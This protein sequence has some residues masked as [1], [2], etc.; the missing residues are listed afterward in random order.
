[1]C[2]YVAPWM[3]NVDGPGSYNAMCRNGANSNAYNTPSHADSY[4]MCTPS[5]ETL[6]EV[7]AL[8][9]GASTEDVT[10]VDSSIGSEEVAAAIAASNHASDEYETASTDVDQAQSSSDGSEEANAVAQDELTERQ[11]EAK[12]AT[13][14]EAAAKANCKAAQEAE[15]EAKA[16]VTASNQTATD[17]SAAAAHAKT[18]LLA[19]KKRMEAKKQATQEAKVAQMEAIAA[20]AANKAKEFVTKEIEKAEKKA[21]EEEKAEKAEAAAKEAVQKAE[22]EKHEKKAEKAEKEAA[23]KEAKEKAAEKAAKAEEEKAEKEEVEKQAK[24][25]KIEKEEKAQKKAEEEAKEKE[26]KEQQKQEQEKAAAEATAQEQPA[27]EAGAGDSTIPKSDTTFTDADGGEHP[28]FRVQISGKMNH[29]NIKAACSAKGL[30]P[31]C[32]GNMKDNGCRYLTGGTLSSPG[33][34]IKAGLSLDALDRACFYTKF[35]AAGYE[36]LCFEKSSNAHHWSPPWSKDGVTICTTPPPPPAPVFYKDRDLVPAF[37]EGAINHA[38]LKAACSSMGMKPV[39]DASHMTHSACWSTGVQK[40]LSSPSS[41]PTMGMPKSACEQKCF[42]AQFW[43]TKV[44]AYEALCNNGGG[45][46]WANANTKNKWT[47]CAPPPPPPAA[48]TYTN[49]GVIHTIVPTKVHGEMNNSN[50]IAACEKTG[51]KPVCD[52]SHLADGSCIDLTGSKR[53]WTW[54]PHTKAFGVDPLTSMKN[55]YVYAGWAG[56]RG[57]PAR[58]CCSLQNLGNNNRWSNP[59]EKDGFTICA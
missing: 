47:L 2:F 55:I 1:V 28:F 33:D 46:Y 3:A 56:N 45:H 16:G 50:M 51:L 13:A 32:N 36:A 31:V 8:K 11:E 57:N 21:A 10:E 53:S 15:V 42:F 6:A 19:S 39:C 58:Q 14:Q 12:T 44:G 27:A 37:V 17:A 18:L 41:C 22:D 34:A 9:L 30:L 23:K 24:A 5:D 25:D 54:P 43:A 4:V 59:G 52:A 29:A 49:N 7:E 40:H 26:V 38:S 35:W 20:E 48:F